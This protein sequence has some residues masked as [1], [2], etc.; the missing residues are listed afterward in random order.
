MGYHFVILN[1]KITLTFAILALFFAAVSCQVKAKEEKK[2]TAVADKTSK[3]A[4]QDENTDED[5]KAQAKDT[6]LDEIT[7]EDKK[8][9]A[10]DDDFFFRIRF[11]RRRHVRRRRH[12][13]CQGWIN[14]NNTCKRNWNNWNRAC[15]A[16]TNRVNVQINSYKKQIALV[17]K[18]IKASKRQ[19]Y[20]CKKNCGN[21]RWYVR[22]RHVRR[23]NFIGQISQKKA[24][25][26][27]S[28]NSI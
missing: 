21:G 24:M 9:Q 28:L 13:R 4:V 10:K 1:M 7:D 23:R 11:H 5:K 27:T 2:D 25:K 26:N 22:R 19:Y 6:D 15:R 12:N 14:R 8:T 20:N 3:D 18:Q 17:L 16:K